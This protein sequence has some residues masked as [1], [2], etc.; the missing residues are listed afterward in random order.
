M[1]EEQRL[2][3]EEERMRE[4][5][6]LRE[7]QRL[8]EEEE[9][10]RVEK[11]LRE[12]E[13]LRKEEQLVEKNVIENQKNV[14]PEPQGMEVTTEGDQE[15]DKPQELDKVSKQPAEVYSGFGLLLLLFFLF[16]YWHQEFMSF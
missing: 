12:E 1:R 4:E 16:L 13:R 5:E 8:R 11:S 3:E 6:R 9:R 10:M 15:I 2:R 14:E 7:E